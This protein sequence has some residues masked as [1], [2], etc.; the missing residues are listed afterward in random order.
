VNEKPIYIYMRPAY[1]YASSCATAELPYVAQGTCTQDAWH[2]SLVE[3]CFHFVMGAGSGCNFLAGRSINTGLQGC[4]RA[5]HGLG[6][7]K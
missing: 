1:T 3:D 4:C 7:G 5:H 2:H 6:D